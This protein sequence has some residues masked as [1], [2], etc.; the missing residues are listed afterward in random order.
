M[1]YAENTSV[2]SEQ[3]RNEIERTIQRYGGSEFGYMNSQTHAFVM[4]M[5]CDRRVQFALELPDRNSRDFT[6]TEA[7]GTERSDK[8]KREAYEKAIRQKWRALALCVKAKL[9]AVDA[10]ITTF[11]D[12]FMAH[13]VLPNGK[14][15]SEFVRPAIAKAYES[16]D[17]PPML[18]F[19]G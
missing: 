15:A 18:S 19:G 16:G 8:G 4:F 2:N 5:A 1:A 14:T 3:S 9:E 13:I 17:M 7:R 6:H 10:G 11:E 12:E